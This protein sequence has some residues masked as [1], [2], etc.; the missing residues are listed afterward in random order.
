MYPY[1]NHLN[2]NVQAR[3]TPYPQPDQPANSIIPSTGF[4]LRG[5]PHDT[6]V[7]ILAN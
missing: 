1:R 3:P 7:L 5:G 2:A 4:R 6:Q